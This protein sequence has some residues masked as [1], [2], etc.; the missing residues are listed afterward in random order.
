MTTRYKAFTLHLIAS[1][2]VLSLIFLLIQQIWYP[3]KL[4][5]LAAGLDLLYLIV[6]VDLVMGPLVMLIIFDTKKKNLKMDVGIVLLCQ[7]GFLAYGC[8]VMYG[9]RP[10]YFAFVDN[11]FHLVR[12]NEI[13]YKDLR[14]VKESQFKQIP[15]WGPIAVGTQEPDDP[16]IKSDIAFS[17]L[18]G[19]GIQDLPQY[20]VPYTQ[21]SQQVVAAA[22]PSQELKL[23]QFTQERVI[24]YE[25]KHPY[26]SALFVPMV[27]KKTPLVVAIDPK[28]AHI[29]QII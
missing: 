20:F 16:K 3:G 13:D 26:Q 15:L 14:L 9:A 24:A 6:G 4:F 19:M 23:D 8:W 2:G 21:V 22:K 7:L 28:T 5:T 1:I 10:V 18:G 17:A 27:N 29:I 11:R 25:K 12:A